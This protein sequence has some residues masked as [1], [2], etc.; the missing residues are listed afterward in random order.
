M[1][2]R[3]VLGP[4]DDLEMIQNPIYWPRR[5][6]LPVKRDASKGIADKEMGV[7]W[8][9]TLKTREHVT[10]HHAYLFLL[11]K[12]VEELKALPTTTYPTV[13]AMLADGWVVD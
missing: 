3:K 9:G 13:A 7:L 11:P 12:T 1:V 2:A 10:I 6:Y 4:G 5:P 8:V